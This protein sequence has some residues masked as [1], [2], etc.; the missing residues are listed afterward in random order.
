MKLQLAQ[1]QA[2]LGLE[3]EARTQLS[4]I[5]P[6]D[7]PDN[8]L[9]LNVAGIL[10]LLGDREDALEIAISWDQQHLRSEDRFYVGSLAYI[11]AVLGERE[12]AS[13]AAK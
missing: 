11:Y 8:P 10:A 3:E 7:L 13:G 4:E 6:S 5:E 9:Q 12:S 1:L 2:S